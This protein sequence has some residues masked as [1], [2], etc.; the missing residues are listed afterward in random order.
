MMWTQ[1]ETRH[2]PFSSLKN[3]TPLT[4]YLVSCHDADTAAS[5]NI[6]QPD[7]AI[8]GTCGYVVTVGVELNTL[9]HIINTSFQTAQQ[10]EQ[11]LT[12]LWYCVTTVQVNRTDHME[13]HHKHLI[14]NCSTSWPGNP[15]TPLLCHYCS[16]EQ[17]WPHGNT[18]F[19]T[20]P[21][22]DRVIPGLHYCVIRIKLSRDS[23]LGQHQTRDR[24]VV[25]SSPG[26]SSGRI[27]FSI[28]NFLCWLLFGVCS[29]CVAA[30]AC[31]RPPSF[32]QKR[33][34]QLTTKHAY[35]HNPTKLEGADYAVQ[36]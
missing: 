6:P 24:K 27:F 16:G 18:S 35:T 2:K 10:A 29:T 33:R 25:N 15:W 22:A 9:K 34:W 7:C 23:L 8:T 30:V 36:A 1:L 12:C 26:R 14:S 19:Q 4:S 3:K 11:I 20:V 32:C 31:K 13:T 17:N 28:V 21:Q 5:Q